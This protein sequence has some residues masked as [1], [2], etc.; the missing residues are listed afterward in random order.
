MSHP[1]AHNS[2]KKTVGTGVVSMALSRAGKKTLGS[3]VTPAVWL[4]DYQTQGKTP[5]SI[6]VGMF[7]GGFFSASGA[8]IAG[9]V[10]SIADDAVE[11]KLKHVQAKEPKKYR[12]H[13]KA[14]FNFASSPPAIN[15]M[16][17]A[18]LGGTA[19]HHPIGIWVYITDA[20]NHFVA[21]YKPV[22]PTTVYRPDLPLKKRKNGGYAWNTYK[23]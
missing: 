10:K 8:F 21:D 23:K 18:G 19:W 16:T 2:V 7:V 1:N 15:A 5:D 11:N 17:I 4:Y 3:L 12:Q 14:C 9:V 20:N 6:D 13:I 22:N